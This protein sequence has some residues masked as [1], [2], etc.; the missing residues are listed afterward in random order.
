MRANILR[1]AVELFAKDGF[2]G[3]SMRQLAGSVGVTLAAVYHYFPDKQALYDAAIHDAFAYMTRCMI[4]ATR[5]NLRGEARLRSF[6]KSQV[7][8]LLSD[9]QEVRLVDRELL[10]ARPETLAKLG[11]DLFVKPHAALTEIVRELAPDAP[12]EE[13]AEHIIAGAYGAA[14]LRVIRRQLKGVEY[15]S[16][17]DGIVE[18]LMRTTLATLR[19]FRPSD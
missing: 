9:A 17:L 5:S 14:R 15:L 12:A 11:S 18:S 10:E 4:E 8:L 13:L 3:V 1:N 19:G 7:A 16:E 2:D 6:L